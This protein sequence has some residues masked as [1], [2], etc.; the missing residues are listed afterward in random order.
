MNCPHHPEAGFSMVELLVAAAISFGVMAA[1]LGLLHPAQR[2]FQAQPELA[3]M[4]QRIRVAVGSITR[5][6]R[7][8]G[9]GR[10]S[11]V[12][13]VLPY[14]IGQ[15]GSDPDAGVFFRPEALS[16]LFVP[17]GEDAEVSRTYYLHSDPGAD[18]FQLMRYD[19]AGTDLPLVDHVIGLAFEY[20]GPGE[21]LLDPA[22]LQDGPWLPDPAAGTSFDEDLLGIRRVRVRIRVRAALASMRGASGALFTRGG[23]STSAERSVPD[24]QL[25]FDVTP[26]NRSLGGSGE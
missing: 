25:Q 13:S 1:V 11:H 7:A 8:A 16:L 20:M 14:R 3:D 17:W 26:R 23:T 12:A 24:V 2:M 15:D 22:L 4:H 19:G 5:D 10:P 21:A 9:A 18:A 6:L